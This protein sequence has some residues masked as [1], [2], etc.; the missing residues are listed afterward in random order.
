MLAFVIGPSVGWQILVKLYVLSTCIQLRE[1]LYML[2]TCVC[3]LVLCYTYSKLVP[4]FTIC[5]LN[6]YSSSCSSLVL[7]PDISYVNVGMHVALAYL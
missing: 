6:L 1:M 2:P 7:M 4:K 3:I 5:I